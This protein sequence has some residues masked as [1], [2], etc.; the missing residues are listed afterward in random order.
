MRRYFILGLIILS[1]CGQLA[2]AEMTPR[3]YLEGYDPLIFNRVDVYKINGGLVWLKSRPYRI[4]DFGLETDE[5]I[6]YQSQQ[7]VISTKIGEF[8]VV[9]KRVVSFQTY[10]DNVRHKAFRKS[11]LSQYQTR[12]QQT[13]VTTT[14]LIK[15]FKLELPT[16]AMPKAV[17]RVLGSSAGKLNL[18]GT[19][20]V[21]IEAGSTKREN[22]AI[23]ETDNASNFD[24]K[25]KQETN[26]RLSGTI[27]DKI[28]VNLKYNS[29]QDEQLFDPD[30]ISIKYTGDEDEIFQSIEGGNITLA[31][32]G[33]RY[34]SYSTASQGLFGVTSK[35]KYKNLDL[36]LIASTEEGQK[37]TQSYTGTS[38]ADSTVFRSR[39]YAPRTMYYLEDPYELYDLYTETDLS[40]NVPPGWVNNAIKTDATGAW[41][42]KMPMLL[43][44]NGSVRLFIDDANPDNNNLEAIG[45][46]IYFSPTDYYVPSYA[47]QIEGTDFVTDYSA[48]IIR[49]NKTIDRRSTVAVQYVRRD[50]IP[51]PANSNEQDGKIHAK[52]IKRR[53]QEYD[54][55]DPNNVWHYQMRNVYDMHKTNIKNDG[56]RLEIYTM[57]VD[58]TRNYMVPDSLTTGN[59]VTYNDYLRMD[60]TGDG[61]ING[62]DNTVNLT[63]GLVMIPFIQPFEPLGDGIVYT[64][65]G[66][67]INYLDIALY[68]SI[69][70]KIGRESVDL[71][72]GGIL[73]GSVVVKVN[74]VEQK[75]NIDYLVDYDF[76]RITFLTSAGK[77]P[78]A[79]IEID[80]EYRSTF[81]VASKSLAGVRADWNI[82]DWAK[83]GGTFIYRSENVNDRRP[84]IGNEN[85]EMIMADVD[86]SL[87]FKPSFITRMLNALPLIN[88]S[89]ESRLTLSG[90]VAYTI[91]NIYGDPHDKKKE[92][93]LDDMESIMDSYPMGVTIGSWSQASKPWNS[94]LAKG[95]T[96]WYNPKNI[97][98]EQVEDP[99]TLTDRE[100]KETVTALAI[101]VFPSSLG[102]P[103]SE[104]WSWGGVMKYLGN[105]LDFSQKKYIEL[106]VKVVSQEG[107]PAPNPIL[108]ID[109]GDIN[110]DFYTDYGGLNVL[111]SEDKDN[112]GVLILAEDTGLDG[113]AD[114]EPGDDPNDEAN[115]DIDQAGDYP[116]ING[117]E[118]NRVLDTEDLNNDGVL[119]MLD[120]YFSYSISLSDTL[121][122][123]NV[124]ADGWRLYRIPITDPNVF[125]IVNN[126]STGGLPTLKKISFGRIVVETDQEA[127]VLLYDINVVGNKWEDFYVRDING[128]LL[129]ESVVSTYN[130][131]YLS[132]IVNNQKNSAHYVSPEG[133]FY[134][135]SRRESSESALSLNVENLQPGHEVLL[136]QRL[137]DPYSLLSY[138]NLKFWV[139][140][141]ASA[142]NPFHP[143]SVDVVFRVGADSLNW[144]QV[145][146]RV[147][148]R[149]YYTKMIREDWQ[150]LTYSLQDITTLKEIDPDATQG[151]IVEGNKVYSFK[152]TPTLTNVRDIYLGVLSPNDINIPTPYNGTVYFNDMRVTEPYEDVGV[153]KRLSLNSTFAD[154][155]TLDIDYE[156]KSENFNTTIQ[157]GRTNSFTSSRT[158]NIMNKYFL[159]KLFPNSWALDIPIS[160]YRN[161]TLGIPRFQ[162]NSDLLRENITDPVEKNRQRN[163]NLVYAADFGFSQRQ[164]PRSKI[165]QY[166]LYRTSV[167]GRI[168]K[169][170][171]FSPTAADTTFTW[172]GTLNY[173]LGLQ[174]DKVS[175]PILKNYRIGWFPT[176]WNNSITLSNTEPQSWN[177]EKREGVYG[178][179][180]RSQTVPTKT[181]TSDTN[182]NWGLTSDI[183]L[184]ARL[185]TERDLKQRIYWKDIN[186]G[187]LTQYVQDLGLNYN[188]NY[189]RSV[190]NLTV[191]GTT[192]F[193]ESQRKYYQNTDEGQIELYQS[194]GSSNRTLRT[195]LTLMNSTLLSSLANKIS[196]SHA[197]RQAKKEQERAD[198]EDKPADK[199]EG[200]PEDKKELTDEEKQR[201]E[202]ERKKQE[203]D[204]L[205]L[206]Y[207]KKL[208]EQ[209]RDAEKGDEGDKPEEDNKPE[210]SGEVYEYDIF[211][212]ELPPGVTMNW[213]DNG[214]PLKEPEG[215]GEPKDGDKPPKAA[216]TYFPAK[217]IMFLSKIKN[218]TASYQNAYVQSYSRKDD[219]PPFMFQLGLP[220]STDPDYLDSVG[221]DNTLTLAS[222]V[223][224]SRKLDSIISYSYAIDKNRADA[225]NQT[226]A[227]TF[228]DLTLS[229]MDF[230]SWIGLSKYLT[231][232]RLN[233]GFQYTTRASGDIDWVKPKQET[234]SIA[235]NPLLGF[236]GT[237]FKSLSTN[238]S[239]S[240]TSGTNTTDMDTYN[241]V[242]TNLT[243]SVNGNLS[244]SF[245]MGRGFTIPF[246]K[247][248]IHIKNE[249]TSSLSVLFEKNYDE[250]FGRESSQIDRDAV[251]I[252]INPG[253][254]YQFNS[255]IRG[256]LTGTWEKTSDNKR[257]TGSRT[258]RIGVWVEVNL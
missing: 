25:M 166:T 61:L 157:R 235:L 183:A 239:Y 167:S 176:T 224:F 73:K 128:Q 2:A 72:Q 79:K 217:M 210:D 127:K 81:E 19:E 131:S 177:W 165:L 247:K 172:R 129:P 186:I 201:L 31:L 220:H 146:E 184:T 147:A 211:S 113:I 8:E 87:T 44:E 182:I 7:V 203:E 226:V 51:V 228:P 22:V 33:S 89:A 63:T 66:E 171:R 55:T 98:R 162:A 170:Y 149:P 90:E 173:N 46:T 4:R 238:I 132:G 40:A 34:I 118:G 86:G 216:A 14:G 218:V 140:P 155:S 18:D 88:T 60:S 23:Y 163:E 82:T 24:I 138:G 151:E 179:Y 28:G 249:L 194:D 57:N 111:N 110:E 135:E 32:S 195:N 214:N 221:D 204:Q 30:N 190:L 227:V 145:R 26:L 222:G 126:A 84:R 52:V 233:T 188:P 178:W 205:K 160:L 21:T 94:T 96:N 75:E 58:L 101:K 242:K 91:P 225:S 246:T 78:D 209:R 236:T 123:E 174:S 68:L 256:G 257:D 143:D 130:T 144:Y 219:R 136:R 119:S 187:K 37:N 39:D 154:V 255:D 137:F 158:L 248:K 231:T 65:E 77:D 191:S 124:N 243:H 29:S 117:T 27:G 142:S 208:E 3:I 43:P 103:G 92:A 100:K 48:G 169:A 17:Q 152:G 125:Q 161:Y 11:L 120:R 36:T 254:T 47:E 141:E 41:L 258:F 12:T 193:S 150:E 202:E 1:F 71:A 107:S 185:N 156:D 102:I 13:S 64:D 189:L 54:P 20:K 198:A 245:R 200:E 234:V 199:P 50:G 215:E 229:L 10:F 237:F 109:L 104:V 42:I 112:D 15:E 250:T 133:T 45:D 74:G 5:E 69:K 95:R 168:E 49:I 16:I 56:F 232:A 93:Y 62:D 85:I 240:L 252:A 53:N 59:V 164:A 122:L 153:A 83:L 6:D 253:A 80:Y 99:S 148:V 134:I 70:G 192:R 115:N 244:Y 181:F 35:L 67:S 251:R 76:G 108:R 9:P 139:Y 105:Q 223:S 196:A 106:M 207:L 175:F 212:G 159:N 116:K 230:E 241:I 121:F 38:Q 97:R 114:K 197:A 206:D 213:G 180:P